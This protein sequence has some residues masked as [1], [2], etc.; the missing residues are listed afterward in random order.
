MVC[1]DNSAGGQTSQVTL[2]LKESQPFGD[3]E[4][5]QARRS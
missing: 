3:L 1:H 4:D 5:L 2:S